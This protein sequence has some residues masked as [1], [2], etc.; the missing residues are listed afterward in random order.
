[1]Y[2]AT[3]EEKQAEMRAR[4]DRR[5]AQIAKMIEDRAQ[6]KRLPMAGDIP[7]PIT[8]RPCTTESAL[9]HEVYQD[10]TEPYSG[11]YLIGSTKHEWYKVG[12]SQALSRR[13]VGYRSLPFLI[14]V[15]CTWQVP[16]EDC[17]RIEKRI[18][19]L[20]ESRRTRANDGYSEW[21]NLTRD[22]IANIEMLMENY[23]AFDHAQLDSVI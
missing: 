8:R 21:Y 9:R 7:Y 17:R 13:L 16:E 3:L 11:V 23:E 19:R 12:Q 14:D 6:A 2:N 5:R 4:Q 22:D 1:M 18:H 15:R 20:V 10:D